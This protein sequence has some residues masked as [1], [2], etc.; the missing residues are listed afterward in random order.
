MKVDQNDQFSLFTI[1]KSLEN[2]LKLN[3][4]KSNRHKFLNENSYLFCHQL[5]NKQI[6]E[7]ETNFTSC[8]SII[9]STLEKSLVGSRIWWR[10]KNAAHLSV[11]ENRLRQV[12]VNFKIG[13][14]ILMHGRTDTNTHCL[15]SVLNM[16]IWLQYN[17][18]KIINYLL[19][20]A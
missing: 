14:Y 15:K 7:N 8:C 2:V 10:P 19:Y 18:I 5:S 3:N 1:T 4:Q 17:T 12:V 13:W 11:Y 20:G 6:N 9:N 16:R